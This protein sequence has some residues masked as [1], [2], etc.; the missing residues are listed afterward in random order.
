MHTIEIQRSENGTWFIA[1]LLNGKLIE[2]IPIMDMMQHSI[3]MR[4]WLNK[5]S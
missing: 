1:L 2:S 5:N 3:A 4:D